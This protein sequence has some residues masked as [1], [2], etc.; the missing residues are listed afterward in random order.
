MTFRLKEFFMIAGFILPLQLSQ[1]CNYGRMNEQEY[2]RT[3]E[4]AI[5][6]MPDGTVPIRGGLEILKKTDPKTLKNPIPYREESIIQ[7]KQAYLYFCVQC[8]GPQADGRGTV[9]QSFAPLPSNLSGVAVQEQSDGE[10]FYKISLGFNRHPALAST[11][12]VD[13]LWAVVVYIR[14]LKPRG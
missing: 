8:H 11:V 3:Y 2:F 13:D 5:P 4:T 12:V 9:G 14:S 7:G 6:E 10:L 1:G